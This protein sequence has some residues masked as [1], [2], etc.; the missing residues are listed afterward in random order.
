VH[1]LVNKLV[2]LGSDTIFFRSLFYSSDSK[3]ISLSSLSSR[4]LSST[5]TT[6]STPIMPPKEFNMGR[7]RMR[8]VALHIAYLGSNYYG[9]ASQEKGGG[10]LQD[11]TPSHTSENTTLTTTRKRSRDA[12][13]TTSQPLS[14]ASLDP[15][16]TVESQLFTA[17]LKACLIESR[18]SAGYTRCGRTDR[19]VSSGGQ[20]VSLRIRSK[21]LRFDIPKKSGTVDEKE[22]ASMFSSISSQGC[23]SDALNDTGCVSPSNDNSTSSSISSSSTSSSSS[24]PLSSSSSSTAAIFWNRNDGLANTG[25]PFPPRE[26]EADYVST[27]NSILPTDIRVLGWTDVPENFS[28]RFSATLRTYRYYFIR[29]DL[30]LEA[31]RRAGN[32][33]TGIHDF[34]NVCKIDIGNTQ[35]FIREILSIK[36]ILADPQGTTGRNQGGVSGYIDPSLHS[37]SSSTFSTSDSSSPISVYYIEVIGRAFLWH[38]IRCVAALLFHVGRGVE[39]ED[40]I[41]LLLDIT[42]V[43]ARPQYPMAK[44]G[45]LILQHCSFGEELLHLE[46]DKK[47]DDSLTIYKAE[48]EGIPVNDEGGIINNDDETIS[49]SRLKNKRE[50]TLLENLQEDDEEG[51]KPS[52]RRERYTRSFSSLH[53]NWFTS[54]SSIR[55]I[56]TDLEEQWSEAVIKAAML[57]GILDRVYNTKVR[58]IDVEKALAER[59][60]EWKLSHKEQR[61]I[62]VDPETNSVVISST[63]SSSPSFSSSSSSTSSSSMVQEFQ[64]QTS[65]QTTSQTSSQTNQST[66][67]LSWA[68]AVDMFGGRANYKNEETT[69]RNNTEDKEERKKKCDTTDIAIHFP[70]YT[71]GDAEYR[72]APRAPHRPSHLSSSHITSGTSSK[73]FHVPLLS[74]ATGKG[75]EEKWKDLSPKQRA[76]ISKLHPVNAP[77]LDQK[78]QKS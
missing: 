7:Y 65:S 31:M 25:A 69:R 38:Q 76:E 39:T 1:T 24:S 30:D 42:K 46:K 58:A 54:V 43:P 8:H 72:V 13:I 16:P 4:Y 34:R 23:C 61:H 66:D 37:T 50:T 75:V 41:R 29:R 51:I 71:P 14:A 2:V 32:V 45:P 59:N 33:L 70:L 6:P 57:R 11:I 21:A 17:L 44:E 77:L 19:G 74:R 18:S 47:E 67:T 20:V 68:Q 40:T 22:K 27:L 26:E 9:F 73:G 3:K 56:T 12:L 15:Y 55:K 63:S 64:S 53:S 78:T 10:D 36:L 48:G 28:A 35:N 5:T 49:T 62:K 52:E 60:P